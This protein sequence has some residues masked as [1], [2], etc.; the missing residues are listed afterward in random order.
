MVAAI[1]IT[2]LIAMNLQAWVTL[3]AALQMGVLIFYFHRAN[4]CVYAQA[5]GASWWRTLAVLSFIFVLNQG[6]TAIAIGMAY[7]HLSGLS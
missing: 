4:R 1:L 7:S 5:G 3:V 6:I 2:S